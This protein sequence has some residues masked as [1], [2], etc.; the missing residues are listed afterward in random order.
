MSSQFGDDMENTKY[1]RMRNHKYVKS[2]RVE[3]TGIT[4]CEVEIHLL[5]AK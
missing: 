4:R 1:Q 3:S 5:L 2:L